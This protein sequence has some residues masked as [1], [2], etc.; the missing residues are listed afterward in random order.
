MNFLTNADLSDNELETVT[1]SLQGWCGTT[2]TD[3]NSLSVQTAA[4]VAIDLLWQFPTLTA[5]ELL[6]LLL[7]RLPASAGK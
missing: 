3:P 1:A 7:L 5:P 6:E 2:R 4:G